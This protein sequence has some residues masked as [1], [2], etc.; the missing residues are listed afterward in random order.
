MPLPNCL[1][2]LIGG[3]SRGVEVVAVDIGDLAVGDGAA[4]VVLL[5]HGQGH[6]P[7]PDV[8]GV[9]GLFATVVVVDFIEQLPGAVVEVG[10]GVTAVFF[11]Q[12]F[13]SGIMLVFCLNSAVE[14]K[15]AHAVAG[16]VG[17]ASGAVLQGVAVVV[18]SEGVAVFC[19]QAV[20]V[21]GVS[22]GL[23]V[24]GVGGGVFTGFV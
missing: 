10:E 4:A 24:C 8:G 11:K 6:V 14:F 19:G 21:D 2:C 23:V 3:D 7:E 5:D 13:A 9:G 1:T 16:V 20:A 18:V 17:P 22:E 15:L 12:P